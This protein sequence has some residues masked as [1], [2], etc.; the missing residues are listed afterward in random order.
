MHRC[1]TLAAIL[2]ALPLIG[3][4]DKQAP[5][6]RLA[7]ALPDRA[8][9][10]RCLSVAPAVPTLPPYEALTLP[11]GRVVVLLDRVRER[12]AITARFLVQEREG[13]LLCRASTNYADQWTV[14]AARAVASGTPK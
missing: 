2:L 10:E 13:R 6:P 4:G 14:E 12:D 8:Q 1:A 9:F 5:P 3:C 7:L 11:D